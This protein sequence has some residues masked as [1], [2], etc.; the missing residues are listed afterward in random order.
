MTLSPITYHLL[1]WYRENKRNLPW[2][3]TTNPY[4]VWVSEII[5]QQTRVAQGWDYYLRFTRR[6][7][8]VH[9]LAAASEEEVLKLWQGLGYYSRA[10][11]MHASARDIMNRL[12]GKFP[13]NYNDILSLKGIGDY[14]A[15]AISSIA[16]NEP[17]AAVDGNVLRVIARLF[18]VE[19]SIHT[20]KGKRTIKEITQTLLPV[21]QPGAFNQAMMDLGAL[22]CTPMQPSCDRC[23]LRDHCMAYASNRTADLPKTN[24]KKKTRARYFNYFHI[25][26]D[27]FT[28]IS[29]RVDQD[30]WKNLYEFPLVETAQSID[31][32]E[33]INSDEFKKLF[34]G[35]APL[36]ID[37]SIKI[38]HVLSHQLIYARF[39]QVHLPGEINCRLP[40][41]FIRTQE[42]MLDQFPVSRLI[43][44]YLEYVNNTYGKLQKNY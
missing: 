6:F 17:Y 27:G 34:N 21:D 25:F 22:I 26:H 8:D 23:P 32:K 16:F 36:A 44:K 37:F 9:S 30:I 41:Q 40:D 33:L 13:D 35:I 39:Y 3:E 18:E 38:K 11:N 31:M 7:P 12:N 29:Q 28:Y 42:G 19:E 24:K 2:R 15:A 43:H 4:H 5:L 1:N 10:R 20:A 14:T